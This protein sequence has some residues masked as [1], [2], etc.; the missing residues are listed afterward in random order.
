MKNS[1]AF[2]TATF[3]NTHFVDEKYHERHSQLIHRHDDVIELLYVMQGSGSYLVGDHSYVVQPGSL[4]ICNANV[5]HGEPPFQKHNLQSYCCVLSGL[6][7]PDLPPNTLMG[8]SLHPVLFFSQDKA[9]IENIMLTMHS[10]NTQSDEYHQVCNLLAN[11]LLN[12]VY[13]KLQKRQKPT[14]FNQKGNEDFIQNITQYL[15]EHYMEAISLQDLASIF[16][17]SHYYFS[18]IFK[19]ETGISPMRYVMYRRIGEAQNMLMNTEMTIGTIGET[20]GFGDNCHF[21]SMFKKYVGITP[22][23]YRKHFQLQRNSQEEGS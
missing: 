11:A 21:S 4:V 3:V 14:E 12:I 5:L 1:N 7:L 6:Q 16:H 10:L 20:L 2:P 13:M 23:Q 18:H 19:I 9:D 22:T 8:G 15:D 17:M